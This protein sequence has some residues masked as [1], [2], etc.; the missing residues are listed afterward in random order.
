MR[1]EWLLEHLPEVIVEADYC[2]KEVE[3]LRWC[4]L[5]FADISLHYEH[6]YI[7]VMI[8]S[9]KKVRET[10]EEYEVRGSGNSIASA[11]KSMIECFPEVEEQFCVIAEKDRTT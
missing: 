8:R 7:S 5:H 6:V 2:I 4:S 3:A 11:V 9:G 10:G 1:K